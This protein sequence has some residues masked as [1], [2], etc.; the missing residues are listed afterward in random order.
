MGVLQFLGHS[1]F[2][3]EGEGIKAL[4]DPFLSGNPLAAEFAG[5]AA[6]KTEV[7]IMRPGDTLPF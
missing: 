2:Y 6:G 3:V 4:I 5:K 1:A 7:I